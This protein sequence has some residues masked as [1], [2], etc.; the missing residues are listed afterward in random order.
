MSHQCTV[1]SVYDSFMHATKLAYA[2]MPCFFLLL[3]AT[4]CKISSATSYL[5]KIV[6]DQVYT[7]YG[8]S[9]LCPH[10]LLVNQPARPLTS[11]V[12]MQHGR[13]S[14]YSTPGGQSSFHVGRHAQQPDCRLVCSSSI[15]SPLL[16]KAPVAFPHNLVSWGVPSPP[17]IHESK[18]NQDRAMVRT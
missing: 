15:Y 16:L 2:D 3:S 18:L 11:P 10:L 5:P 14:P 13:S 8:G 1:I 6:T 17:G 9:P 12:L 4:K 7:S